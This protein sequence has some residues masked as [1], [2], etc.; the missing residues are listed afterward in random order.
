MSEQS[1]LI[2]DFIEGRSLLTYPDVGFIISGFHYKE[3]F[4]GMIPYLEYFSGDG[5]GSFP[6]FG[7]VYFEFSG[8]FC[9]WCGSPNVSDLGICDACLKSPGGMIYSA[10]VKGYPMV[11]ISHNYIIYIGSFGSLLKVGISRFDRGGVDF[12]FVSRLLEQGFDKAVVLVGDFDLF[13]ARE[14]EAEVSR[15]YRIPDKLYLSD[16]LNHLSDDQYSLEELYSIASDII[17]SFSLNCSIY[18]F[19]FDWPDALDFSYVWSGDIL[20]GKVVSFRGN[21][22]FFDDGSDVFVVDL[23]SLINRGIMSW[24]V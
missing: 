14:I 2:S 22:V 16:K 4:D 9:K 24:E 1:R 10:I 7:E 12:G 17:S 5:S 20:S 19:A 21:L 13:D 18:S 8:R 23:N 6:L 15:F 3:F 11:P